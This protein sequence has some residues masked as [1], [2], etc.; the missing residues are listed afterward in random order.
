MMLRAGARV[1]ATTRFPQDSALRYSREKDYAVWKDRL[2]IHGLDLRHTPSVELFARYLAEQLPRLDHLV[3][4]ACQT[5]RRPPEFYAHMME[6]ERA[7]LQN[8]PEEL[9]KLLGSYEE[10]RGDALPENSSSLAL[11]TAA[12]SMVLTR[13]R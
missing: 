7:A 2:S 1:I 6:T 10:L 12:R 9:H 5:V 8:M 3:N 11:R 13:R 4:N